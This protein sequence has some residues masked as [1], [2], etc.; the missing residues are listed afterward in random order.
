MK[1]SETD[2]AHMCLID[3]ITFLRYCSYFLFFYFFFSTAFIFLSSPFVFFSLIPLPFSV[4]LLSTFLLYI[5]FLPKHPP[6]HYE[7]CPSVCVSDIS[8]TFYFLQANLEVGD[9]QVSFL[10]PCTMFE[11]LSVESTTASSSFFHLCFLV[12]FSF[13]FVSLFSNHLC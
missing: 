3:K 11:M 13:S 12:L 5:F 8:N 2:S 4:F 10:Y 1:R 9:P 7:F 6:I